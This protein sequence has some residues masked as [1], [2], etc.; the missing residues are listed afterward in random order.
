MYVCICNAVTEG[1]LRRAMRDGATTL[2]SLRKTLAVGTCCGCCT[3]YVETCFV[4]DGF[5]GEA[6]A[7]VAEPSPQIA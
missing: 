3:E 2:E 4:K 6:H 7:E 1:Q 5:S